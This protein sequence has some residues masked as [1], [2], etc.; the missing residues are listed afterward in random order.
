MRKGE[1]IMKKFFKLV[2][3]LVL[4]AMLCFAPKATN[5][6]GPGPDDRPISYAYR[7]RR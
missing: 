7:V 6:P 5:R 3:C 2:L 1:Y 4:V